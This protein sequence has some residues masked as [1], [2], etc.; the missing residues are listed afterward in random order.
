[1]TTTPPGPPSL[2]EL[3]AAPGEAVGAD[4]DGDDA[5][6]DT[7]L[8]AGSTPSI[9]P[10][11]QRW[12]K[13]LREDIDTDV[14]AA[15]FHLRGLIAGDGRAHRDIAEAMGIGPAEFT[16]RFSLTRQTFPTWAGVA[17]LFP[18]LGRDPAAF[19]ARWGRLWEAPWTTK[20]LTYHGEPERFPTLATPEAAPTV[21]P[22]PR[23]ETD[24]SGPD[25]PDLDEHPL[26]SSELPPDV[27]VEPTSAPQPGDREPGPDVEQA[28]ECIAPEADGRQ[29]DLAPVAV[30]D[31]SG[32]MAAAPAG[33]PGA[34]DQHAATVGETRLE[35]DVDAASD[36]A[37][38]AD[39]GSFASPD[40]AADE[41]PDAGTEDVDDD[42]ATGP[43]PGLPASRADER[44]HAHEMDPAGSLGSLAA[45]SRLA[46]G[47]A[48]PRQDASDVDRNALFGRLAW[49]SDPGSP[50]DAPTGPQAVPIDAGAY[51]AA[52]D[53]DSRAEVWRRWLGSGLTPRRSHLVASGVALA[54]TAGL[55]GW[56]LAPSAGTTTIGASVPPAPPQEAPWT[57]AGTVHGAGPEGVT[58][59]T[60][61]TIKT[62]SAMANA[63]DGAVLHIQ[64]G[65]TGDNVVDSAPIPNHSDTWLRTDEGLFLSM[66]YVTLPNKASIVNCTPGEPELSLA[67]IAAT[68]TS[69]VAQVATRTPSRSATTSASP[70]ATTVPPTTTTTA[71]SPQPGD[72]NYH[73]CDDPRNYAECDYNM[74]KAAAT[75]GWKP[76]N[77]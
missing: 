10:E 54:V 3:A 12:R 18:V 57:W 67:P 43:I 32:P 49:D 53:E 69:T 70:R 47:T 7:S 35:E 39:A 41:G 56:L 38:P 23:T 45:E 64:C 61:P 50:L 31:P 14:Y 15:F 71:R 65:I 2:P 24:Q 58:L 17:P 22:A 33:D 21:I 52:A 72:A 51:G 37:G 11:K 44:A 40:T 73:P 66:L 60:D 36:A 6:D 5:A 29:D 46:E 13:P 19:L 8:D 62:N 77:S 34:R 20:Q 75:P 9:P 74:S 55:L 27:A 30:P 28:D 48:A 4:A 1:M 63:A 25:Q 68:A 42:P 16:K 76:S 59:R 26:N